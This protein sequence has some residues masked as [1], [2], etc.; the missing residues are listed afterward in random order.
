M[1]W[2]IFILSKKIQCPERF[3]YFLSGW[4]SVARRSDSWPEIFNVDDDDHKKKKK[5]R[6]RWRM[7]YSSRVH[8]SFSGGAESSVRRKSI[9]NNGPDLHCGMN[10]RAA[11]KYVVESGRVG[12][13]FIRV[14]CSEMEQMRILIL[15]F[16]RKL[17]WNGNVQMQKKAELLSLLIWFWWPK[18][19]FSHS[20][21][22]MWLKA[23]ACASI[24]IRFFFM[25]LVAY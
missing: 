2:P 4:K 13:I 21:N 18:L 20:R 22:E 12:K 11:E 23:S 7:V 14:E 3:M 5:N 15:Y 10:C 9:N 16:P 25:W 8:Y 17:L 19:K 24:I 1:R 6:S